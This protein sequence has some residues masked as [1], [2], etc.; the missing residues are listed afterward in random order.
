MGYVKLE[1]IVGYH[2]DEEVWCAEC[3]VKADK[4][5][6][7][8][9]V[10]VTEDMIITESETASTDDLIFCDRCKGQMA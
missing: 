9:K 1:D 3:W 8:N 2:H 10:E 7:E 6:P 5:K 4:E